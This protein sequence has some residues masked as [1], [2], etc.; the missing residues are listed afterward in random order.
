MADKKMMKTEE[1]WEKELTPEQYRILRK[2]GTEP[3]FTGAFV[4]TKDKGVYLC[5]A[6]GHELFSSETKFD[7]GT[8]W[9]SFWAPIKTENVETQ[10][11]KK[12]GMPGGTTSSIPQSG[13]SVTESD[14][15]VPPGMHR[16]EA[17]CSRCGS[18]L[19]HV[20]DDGPT[21]FPENYEG[22][23]PKPT[24]KRFCINSASLHFKKND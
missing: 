10:E 3:P 1:E 8:G 7:S 4:H 22:Q 2:K 16:T 5:A 20:F 17:V 21:S 14:E 11:D 23:V 19:G 15:V 13:I 24:G 12:F 18:H 6:C 9:P